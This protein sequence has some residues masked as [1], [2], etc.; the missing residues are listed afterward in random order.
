M[1]INEAN[2]E[3]RIKSNKSPL[4]I[5]N[6]KKGLKNKRWCAILRT[7]QVTMVMVKAIG[8]YDGN[9]ETIFLIK[10]I[11]IIV[12]LLNWQVLYLTI[13]PKGDQSNRTNLIVLLVV[14]IYTIIHKK[15]ECT[16]KRTSSNRKQQTLINSCFVF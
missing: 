15:T 4:G 2:A 6:A 11:R 10:S 3:V 12:H 16:S 13:F 8:T 5:K 7:I 1:P 14:K 9:F